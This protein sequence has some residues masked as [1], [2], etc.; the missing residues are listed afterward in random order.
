MALVVKEPSCQCKRH[1]RYRFDPWVEK[2]PERRKW[3]PTLVF[4]PIE[5]HGQ[6]SLE[7]YSPQG[8]NESG[9]N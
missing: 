1:K 6:Q 8:H 5:S 7:V 3:Q 4:W 2:I 9:H